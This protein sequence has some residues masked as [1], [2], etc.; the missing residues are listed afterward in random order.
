MG[1]SGW[2]GTVSPA[3]VVFGGTKSVGWWWVKGSARVEWLRGV[4]TASMSSSSLV[5][6]S[7]P[8]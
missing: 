3:G 5:A 4:T 1:D 7:V 2:V 8:L 6:P